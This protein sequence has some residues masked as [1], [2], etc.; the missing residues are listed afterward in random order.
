MTFLIDDGAPDGLYTYVSNGEFKPGL[1]T[2]PG[3]IV[4]ISKDMKGLPICAVIDSG[5]YILGFYKEDRIV[6]K[7]GF[8]YSS[9][10]DEENTTPTGG[11]SGN[12]GL[13]P[14][15]PDNL[16]P[17]LYGYDSP[18]FIDENGDYVD[19]DGNPLL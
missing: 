2:D 1:I 6:L 17:E 5:T 11:V 14:V 19:E 18:V 9:V 15:N 10:K 4:G 16:P 3:V 13:T 7:K 8:Y 12:N